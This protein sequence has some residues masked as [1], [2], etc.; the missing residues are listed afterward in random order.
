MLTGSFIK[1]ECSRVDVMP[2]THLPWMVITSIYVSGNAT[3]VCML[4]G[5][6]LESPRDTGGRHVD[7]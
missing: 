3:V 4:T 5:I 7:V 2:L 1:D 6:L